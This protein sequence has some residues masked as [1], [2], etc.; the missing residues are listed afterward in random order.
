MKGL[1][2]DSCQGNFHSFFPLPALL[3]NAKELVSGVFQDD[4]PVFSP[5]A[6]KPRASRFISASHAR[7][8]S[9]NVKVFTV[10]DIAS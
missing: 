3:P 4:T 7:D 1:F 9:L 8:K 2:P 6:M 5:H 10:E